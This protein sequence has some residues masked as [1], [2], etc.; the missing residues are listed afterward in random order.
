[1]Q[2][3]LQSI[4]VFTLTLK[5]FGLV[6]ESVS[7]FSV[8]LKCLCLPSLSRDVPVDGVSSQ[9]YPEQL[10]ENYLF[11]IW[12]EGQQTVARQR[13][14][15]SQMNKPHLPHAVLA[16]CVFGTNLQWDYCFV[17]RTWR[18]GTWKREYFHGNN[19]YIYFW[20]CIHPQKLFPRYFKLENSSSRPDFRIPHLLLYCLSFDFTRFCRTKEWTDRSLQGK[21]RKC[22]CRWLT[23][24]FA[25]SFFKAELSALCLW[26]RVWPFLSH[27]PNE[28]FVNIMSSW[29]L[30]CLGTPK[31]LQHF[32]KKQLVFLLLWPR[33][34]LENFI[35]PNTSGSS[36]LR[37]IIGSG[38]DHRTGSQVFE[39]LLPGRLLSNGCAIVG[40]PL[41]PCMPRFLTM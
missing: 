17:I 14:R 36:V 20:W 31:T 5:G 32:Y 12:Q 28:V 19:K 18:Q 40:S 21:S 29:G 13:S 23:E 39:A 10:A 9:L 33:A 15:P 41:N 4:K 27:P 2:L 16:E 6:P 25:S 34:S 1:M 37:S 7:S 30:E 22:C 35:V 38:T 3:S 24:C 8:I 11:S 26:K